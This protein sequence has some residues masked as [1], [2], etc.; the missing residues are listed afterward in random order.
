MSPQNIQ[1]YFLYIISKLK[2]SFNYFYKN[3]F[4]RYNKLLNK[5][6]VSSFSNLYKTE[7]YLYILYDQK[8][9]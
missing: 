3:Y 6:K 1:I 9:T 4:D 7:K 8:K 2:K 5:L